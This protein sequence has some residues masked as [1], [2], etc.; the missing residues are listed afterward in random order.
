[1]FFD[2]GVRPASHVGVVVSDDT[3]VHAP[4]SRGVVRTEH[5]SAPY[6]SSRFVGARRLTKG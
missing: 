1:V 3:F 5:L 2:T 6:W 4:S